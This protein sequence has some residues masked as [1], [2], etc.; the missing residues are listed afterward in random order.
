[1]KNEYKKRTKCAI[2]DNVNLKTIINYGDVPLAG[3]FPLKEDFKNERKYN[4]DLQFCEKCSLLQTDSVIDSKVL[5]EDYRYMSSVGLSKHFTDV[6]SFL[7]K[8]FNLSESSKILEIGSNDGV[9]LKPLQYLG[10]N[11][12]G[13]EPAVN[14]NKIALEN[15]C[16]VINDYFNDEN[17]SKYFNKNSFDLIISNNCFAHIDDIH[18]IVKGVN[19]ILKSTGYFVIEVHY[20]K[21]LIEQL[22]YDNIYHEHIYY[23]SLNSLKNLF[24]KF[25]MTIVDFEE[26]PVHS[27]SIR[28]VI[29]NDLVK[30]PK[31]VNKKLELEKQDGLTELSY[32]KNFG[33]DVKNHIK[34]IYDNLID[35]KSKGYRIAGY[36]ASGRANMLCN[37]ANLD[38]NIIDFIVDESPERCGRHIAVKQIPIVSKEHLLNNKPDFIMIFA[39][40]FS[41]MII[42]KLEGND[43]KYIIG[44]PEF[45]II[46]EYSELNNFI[47]I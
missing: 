10:L 39:W 12:I 38:S 5:F 47:S 44:F 20:V 19:K 46:K 4:M 24:D 35:L 41:K 32:F 11:P 34:M 23:Y 42:E 14:I 36:G 3:D 33:V 9:L 7:K 40:N 15:G 13:I 25:N 1:M 31:H 30:I 21:N 6:A 8:K 43:F 2:C 37:L 29:C 22:Q 27:G 28:V 45:K 26:I 17:C 16:N 18:S